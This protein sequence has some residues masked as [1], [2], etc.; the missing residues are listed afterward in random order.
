[1]FW[2]KNCSDTIFSR[3]R[4]IIT[5]KGFQAEP[6]KGSKPL[7]YYFG[8]EALA[9][10]FG[11]CIARTSFKMFTCRYGLCTWEWDW[12][13]APVITGE[14]AGSRGRKRSCLSVKRGSSWRKRQICVR[15]I[16][17]LSLQEFQNVHGRGKVC[18]KERAFNLTDWV[19]YVK[20]TN[21]RREIHMWEPVFLQ[22]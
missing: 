15:T 3:A 20:L 19:V 22:F 4:K 17:S 13:E 10:C 12:T 6:T 21:E 1:M 5:S 11:N 16:C 2:V 18:V 8:F 9:K 7:C 14:Q